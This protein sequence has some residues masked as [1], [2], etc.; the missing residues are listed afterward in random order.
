V[1]HSPDD[2]AA[3][4]ATC[5]IVFW[6]LLNSLG[7]IGECRHVRLRSAGVAIC[8]PPRIIAKLRILYS[9]EKMAAEI[10][11][12]YLQYKQSVRRWI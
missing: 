8:T 7:V 12:P 2:N 10:G 9:E 6:Y 11:E 1:F 5:L 3:E 4:S